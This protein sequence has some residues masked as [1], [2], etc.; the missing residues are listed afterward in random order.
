MSYAAV[1]W[2]SDW[3]MIIVYALVVWA[4]LIPLFIGWFYCSKKRAS[5]NLPPADPW[6]GN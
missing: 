1:H 6:I 3:Y 5:K 2:Y 4:L